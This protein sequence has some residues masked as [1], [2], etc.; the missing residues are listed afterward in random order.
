MTQPRFNR[1]PT[2]RPLDVT[3]SLLVLLGVTLLC[4]WRPWLVPVLGTAAAVLA[5]RRPGGP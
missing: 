2:W 4:V 1:P 5:L 3:I